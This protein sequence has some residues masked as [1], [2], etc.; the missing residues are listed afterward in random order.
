[1]ELKCNHEINGGFKLDSFH[2]LLARHS[3]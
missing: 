3:F 2:D 1:M